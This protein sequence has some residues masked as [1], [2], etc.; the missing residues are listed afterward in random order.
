MKT[1]KLFT[2]GG[3]Q[4]V[5]L[6]REFRMPGEQVRISRDGNRVVLEAMP[7]TGSA[8]VEALNKF[9]DDMFSEGRQQPRMQKRRGH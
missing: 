3:S 2:S 7:P 6:P 4:A 9:S 5:R 1:A 8:M